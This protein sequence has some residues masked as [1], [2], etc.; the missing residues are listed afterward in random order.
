[1]GFIKEY[2]MELIYVTKEGYEQFQEKLKQAE[3]NRQSNLKD[4]SSSCN[5]YVGDGW[6]DNPLY[7]DAMLKSRM[8]DYEISKLLKQE[9]QLKIIEETFDDEL[10]NIND[11]VEVEFIYSNNERE[12]DVIKLTG[13][14]LPNL[15]SNIIEITLNSPIGQCLYKAKIGELCKY[16]DNGKE[17]K[18]KVIKRL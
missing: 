17:I 11:T 9:N 10:V 12:R 7:D 13:M 15:N 4:L 16:R 2:F 8:M 6:H 3:N 5:D 14:Y 18:V 1:M